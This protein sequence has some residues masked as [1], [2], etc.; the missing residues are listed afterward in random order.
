M[1]V[2]SALGKE[3]KLESWKFVCRPQ[4]TDVVL[5]LRVRA[6]MIEKGTRHPILAPTSMSYTH[7]W[8]QTEKRITQ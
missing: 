2:T 4:A 3:W 5:Y 6:N 8:T 7:L 1:H